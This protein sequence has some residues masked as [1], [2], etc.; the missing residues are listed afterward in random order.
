MIETFE[1]LKKH[2]IWAGEKLNLG[3]TRKMYTNKIVEFSGNNLVK[4]ILGQRRVGK[5]YIMRQVMHALLNG[6]TN[7]KNIFYLN[8]ELVDFDAV[9]NYKD[10]SKLID[11]YKKELRIRSK[12]FVFLD[13][14]Q[15]IEGWEKIVNS[16]SQDHRQS[17]EVFISGSNSK[18]LSSEL[19]T[20]LSGRYVDFMIFPFLYD[21]YIEFRKIPRGKKSYL[22]Y[23]K[24]GGLPELFN[25]PSEEMKEHYM[26]A[27]KNTIL[28][29]DIIQRYKIKDSQMLENL[30]KFLT[31]NIGNL[32]SINSIV[33]FL[34]SQK[35]K[36]NHETISNYLSYILESYLFHEVE[37][38]DIKG[39]SILASSKKYYLNDLSFR[40]FLSSSFDFGLGNHLENALYIYFRAQGYRIF[41]GS[42]GKK[43][44]DFI[45]E[46]GQE[47]KYIQIAYSVSDKKVA[48]R[49]FG[50]LEEI[51]DAYEKMVISMDDVS[52]GSK[53]GIGHICAWELK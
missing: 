41:V 15:E 35:I 28:L 13:E 19:A 47:R 22:D 36:T 42:L 16:L 23:L 11:I 30:F 6:G 27:L 53:N 4:V 17:Y 29:K 49:E 46:K 43:E 7:P 45:L 2:N 44:V 50:N 21:E 39:K 1:K 25:L 12:V 31:N 5:S 9:K 26:S 33:H 48:L 10:L 52:L 3:F 24:T 8:K 32:F 14:V 38:F 34:N 37:R 51:H 20:Y 18:M 40:N